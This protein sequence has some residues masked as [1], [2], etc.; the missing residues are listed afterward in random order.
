MTDM[1]L[2]SSRMLPSDADRIYTHAKGLSKC[3]LLLQAEASSNSNRDT[4]HAK[5]IDEYSK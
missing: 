5:L 4:S 1:A 3:K 2:S